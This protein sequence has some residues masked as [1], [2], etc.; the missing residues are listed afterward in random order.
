MRFLLIG[1][2]LIGWAS[3]ASAFPQEDC[4][5]K[6]CTDCHSLTK[7]EAGFL[8]G[9][10][11]DRVLKVDQ[12][13][14]PG[15]WAVEVEKSGRKYPVY[16][17]YSKSHLL[18]GQVV[19]LKDG[20]NLTKLRMASLNRV[21]VS[22]IPLED[23]LIIGDPQASK[24]V[25]VFTDPQCHFCAKLHR[26]LPEVVARDPNIAFYIKLLPLAMHPDAYHIAKSIVCNR[27]M[28]MLEN[29]FDGKSVPPPLCRAEAVDETL[30]L[31]RKLG[32]RSTPTLVLPDGRPFSGYK[33]ADQLLN[34]LDS[35]EIDSS[36]EPGK[37]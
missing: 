31:A 24:K 36:V 19:R 37:R 15:V 5:E 18:R 33:K 29:S 6:R 1:L 8:L 9:A 23:A 7:E 26:E 4:G 10:G 14:M 11:A 25:V 21:D 30:A 12:A 27:S 22:R 32:I 34:L 13:E 2:L 3:I 16:I 28:E 35:S 20:E 17:N